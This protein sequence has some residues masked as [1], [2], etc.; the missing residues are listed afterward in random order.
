MKN[1]LIIIISIVLISGTGWLGV[2]YYQ[3]SKCSIDCGGGPMPFPMVGSFKDCTAAGYPIMESYPR[4]CKTPDG[5]IFSEELPPPTPTYINA[6][7]GIIS[8][9]TPTPGAVTGKEFEVR[10]NA[11][12]WYFEGSFPV[13]ILD[14]NGKILTTSP[15]QAQSDWMT[16]APVRFIAKIK[17]PNSY[18]GKA[19]V[20]LKKDNP[21]ELKENDAS[22]SFPI[23]IEY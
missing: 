17:I 15:A 12:G 23:T 13:E 20:V 5:R 8:V 2:A 18:I 22:M 11:R 14:T 9:T 19:T 10:G 4:Q 6:T 7:S 16:S 3:N 21:S 1:T